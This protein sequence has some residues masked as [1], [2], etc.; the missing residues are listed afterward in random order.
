MTAGLSS[1]SPDCD[2]CHHD[3]HVVAVFRA[4]VVAKSGPLAPSGVTA[5]CDPSLVQGLMPARTLTESRAMLRSVRA[6][7][8]QVHIPNPPVGVKPWLVFRI[9]DHSDLIPQDSPLFDASIGDV[10]CS[11]K[12]H[13]VPGLKLLRIR[14]A[15]KIDGLWIAFSANLWNDAL[16][17][18]NAGNPKVMQYVDLAG[19]SPNTFK[20]TEASLR[21]NVLEF[22][23][24]RYLVNGAA[25]HD[26]PFNSLTAFTEGF[27]Q[28]MQRAAAM[29]PK[30]QGKELAVVLR[31]PVGMAIDLNELRLRRHDMAMQEVQKPEVAHPLNSS[32]L[33][34]GLRKVVIDANL[35]K[36]WD[37]VSPVMSNGAFKDIM[38]VKP[39]PRGWPAETTWEPLDMTPQNK[40]LYGLGAGRVIFP[41]HDARALAWAKVQAEATW[42][43][44]AEH[45]DESTRQAWM[46]AF[47]K[48][49]DAEHFQSLAK[50]ETDWWE[51]CTDVQFR[52]YF[53]HHF[54]EADPND[55]RKRHSPG[56]VYAREVQRAMTPAPL[57]VGL[58]AEDYV[59]ELEK[60]VTEPSAVMLRAVVGNQAELLPKLGVVLDVG[61]G[62]A[63]MLKDRNDKLHDLSSGI[64]LG[65]RNE[66]GTV[67]A[68]YS[69][70]KHSLGDAFGGCTQ[71]I[72]HSL[73]AAVS[74]AVASAGKTMRMR[75]AMHRLEGLQ[76]GQR[77]TDLALSSLVSGGPLKTP[78][79]I[80]RTMPTGQ[81][82]ALL[83]GRSDVSRS[84]VLQASRNGWVTITL[85]T[86]SEELV[87][88]AGKLDEALAQE[89]GRIDVEGVQRAALLRTP[90]ALSAI[91]LSE[92]Q[93]EQ[94]WRERLGLIPKAAKGV[95]DSF[96]GTH[97]MIRSLDARLAFGM[98]VLNGIG[99]WKAIDEWKQGGEGADTKFALAMADSVP[100]LLG[101]ALQIAEVAV[102][103]KVASQQGSQA[104]E[105]V[106]GV[107]T[108]RAFVGAFGAVAA[109][110][111]GI[112][113]AGK[114]WDAYQDGATDRA[115]LY[116]LSGLAFAGTGIT[117][118]LT[119]AGALADRQIA[120]GVANRTA[121]AIAARFGAKGT[122]SL[123]GL[124]VSGWG[125]MLLGLGLLFELGAVVLTPTEL[126]E[127]VRRTYFGKG[128]QKDRFAPGDWAAELRAFE[129][130]FPMS[131][132]A[133]PSSAAAAAVAPGRA[134][135]YK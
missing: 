133:E 9:T 36:S 68:K 54:D 93:F 1:P 28:T 31:D 53:V 78:M 14:K 45:Y 85:L 33:L 100:S 73:S 58:A 80:T 41:D 104:V 114:A 79:Q 40:A 60:K 76:L 84:R 117:S 15:H 38:R 56:V 43:R 96:S 107:H 35:V 27:V 132:P 75:A 77:A 122:A 119:L 61:G 64:V 110:A 48:R 2:A 97:A 126:Q 81:A 39:N 46:D 92:A 131:T 8:L 87:R 3:D 109:I 98:I 115:H 44:T 103:A 72:V 128:P 13:N 89:A 74:A 121:F 63:A 7:F 37:T 21:A 129:R 25:D 113:Q 82:M 20:P 24:S 65:A 106:V 32:N 57:T 120:K 71:T 108:L 16:K 102:K 112:S 51:C 124:S 4:S 62:L 47:N 49:M 34:M 134:A 105:K 66:S 6:G 29:H 23:T 26:L 130:L 127:W 59:A 116:A 135:G 91:K 30:T 22:A 52:N 18:R 19:G 83:S 99:A 90:A 10:R 5:G 11:R 88:F 42:S 86:D 50:F 67:E 118:G 101:G 70:A 123:L 12:G 55:P 69:W 125:L 95:Q 111:N 17:A 94:L